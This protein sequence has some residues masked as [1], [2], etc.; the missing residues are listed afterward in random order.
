MITDVSQLDPNG[1]YTYAD[2]LKWQFEEWVELVDGKYR[3][4]NKPGKSP[5]HQRV[6]KAVGFEVFEK[7]RQPDFETWLTPL[8]IIL[9]NKSAYKIFNL[10]IPDCFIINKKTNQ[11]DE[12]GWR[13]IPDWIIEVAAELTFTL[14]TT[15]KLHLYERYQ[16][17]EYW[18]VQPK[19][20]AVNV[21]V[22]E[23][24]EYALVDVYESGEIPSQIFPDLLISHDR[25]FR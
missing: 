16:V 9:G 15:T 20:K 13:G 4:F 17:R 7:L 8:P 3:V 23:N 25:I 10:T 1:A 22:L 5:V 21:Y 12:T 24:G 2:Y 11:A 19:E 18:I 6:T 14:D